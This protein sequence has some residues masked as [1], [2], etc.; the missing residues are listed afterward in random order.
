MHQEECAKQVKGYN[1]PLYFALVRP[2][3]EYC[4]QFWAP[5]LKKDRELLKR[6]QKRATKTMKRL[7][8][9]PYEEKLE[10]G[11]FVLVCKLVNSR[12]G[13]GISFN[14]NV[15]EKNIQNE[16]RLLK[17]RATRI[18]QGQCQNC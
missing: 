1:L 11:I 17:E 4:V 10:N 18:A 6:A 7:E 13:M 12:K 2:C 15:F 16:G 3:L 14:R 9:L 8:D 5:Q